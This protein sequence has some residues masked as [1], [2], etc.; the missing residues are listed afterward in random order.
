MIRTFKCHYC[1]RKF[2]TKMGVGVH[3][4]RMHKGL[5]I[6]YITQYSQ[7]ECEDINKITDG[8]VL[9]MCGC[10]LKL[11]TRGQRRILHERGLIT[12][13]TYK[14]ARLTNKALELLKSRGFTRV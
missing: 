1:P 6:R 5:R 13:K 7:K 8:N 12:S 10:D 2:G 14:K 3:I 4:G 11:L 9:M